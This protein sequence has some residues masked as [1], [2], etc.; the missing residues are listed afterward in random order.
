MGP[1][2]STYQ[3]SGYLAQQD[4]VAAELPLAAQH[5]GRQQQRSAK[6]P[7][8]LMLLVAQSLQEFVLLALG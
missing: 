2:P 1:Q 7:L 5:P 8:A 6:V 3:R 4:S